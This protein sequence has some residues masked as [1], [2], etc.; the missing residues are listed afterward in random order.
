[1]N[2]QLQKFTNIFPILYGND[3]EVIK[4]QLTRYNKLIDK[5]TAEFGSSNLHLLST[6]G[7]TE[8][9]GNHTDHNMV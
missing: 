3:S 6:P 1:M 2:S 4:N 9:G 8:L 7:R 5:F